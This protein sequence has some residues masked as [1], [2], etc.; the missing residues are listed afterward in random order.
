MYNQAETCGFQIVYKLMMNDAWE[1]CNFHKTNGKVPY[2]LNLL[3]DNKIGGE[4]T[5]RERYEIKCKK[6]RSGKYWNLF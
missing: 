6:R 4:I 1:L 5:A 3:A 2:V